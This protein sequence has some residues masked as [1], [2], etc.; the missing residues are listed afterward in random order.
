MQPDDDKTRTFVPLTG[1]TMVS[2]YRIIEKIGAGGMGDVYLAE[3]TEL[4][5]KVAL[6]FLPPHLCQDSDCR[7]RFKREAQASAK[8]NHPNIITIFE[9][10]EFNDRPYFVMEHVDGCHLDEYVKDKKL[11]WQE[12]IS[13]VIQIAEGI[14]EAHRCGVIHRDIKPSNILADKMGRVRILDFGLA[15]IKGEKKL[16]K[17]GSTLGT[18]HYMSPE[19][20]RGEVL[21]ERSDIFS[22]GVVVY[23]IISGHLPFSGAHEAAIIYS[24]GFEEPEPLGR[25]K[26]G[27]S[28]KLQGII[29]KALAKDKNLRYAH[30]DEM[31]ADLLREEEEMSGPGR[32][33]VVLTSILS[34]R[35][36]G[37]VVGIFLITIIAI[38]VVYL[39]ITRRSSEYVVPRKTQLTFLG[40]A[41]MPEIS[42]DG[43]YLAFVSWGLS[44]GSR[45]AMVQDLAG[46]S[47]IKVFEDKAIYGPRWSPDGSELLLSASNDSVSSIVLVP[48]VGGAF[49]RYPIFGTESAWSPDGSRFATMA[50]RRI[51]FVDRK[52]GDTSSIAGD[53]IY[54]GLDW[55]PNGE[56]FASTMSKDSGLF[57]STCDIHGNRFR[58]VTDSLRAINPKW[59]A[60]GNA[61]YFLEDRGESPPNLFKVRV[62][63]RSGERRGKPILLISSLLG[64]RYRLFCLCR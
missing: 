40:D 41:T 63:A 7:A 19:Q 33:P 44:G 48:R 37:L 38:T 50:W 49:R 13:L 3:D 47:P 27:V 32:K 1:G 60:K 11:T 42:R 26:S 25:Y 2:H 29:S 59:S 12:I 36:R 62:D 30:M 31:L 22:F 8:L 35:R 28:A 14:V 57:I 17:T 9:V 51:Y 64:G 4:N 56:L 46:G 52:S 21:D 61:I 54:Y 45:V 10:G 23:E 58:R 15:A 53:S 5:R 34:Q 20:T 43:K 18:T 39:L 24:I 16:T 6:K 55:S